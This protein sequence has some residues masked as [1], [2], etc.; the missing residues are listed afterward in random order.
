MHVVVLR[1][2][3]IHWKGSHSLCSLFVAVAS[4]NWALLSGPKKIGGGGG[5]FARNRYEISGIIDGEFEIV[6]KI[7]FVVLPG[8]TLPGQHPASPVSP[9]SPRSP[10]SPNSPSRTL[11]RNFKSYHE[12]SGIHTL[13]DQPS[14][15]S[16]AVG[17]HTLPKSY[18]ATSPTTSPLASPTKPR[19]AVI[20]LPVSQ[21]TYW[22]FTIYAKKT[23]GPEAV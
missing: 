21:I 1:C 13:M 17:S 15:H 11:P 5:N 4:E 16:M 6:L 3:S 10:H 7:N 12:A 2:N 14:R 19:E 22:L 8:P 18:K 9:I 23:V 20:D